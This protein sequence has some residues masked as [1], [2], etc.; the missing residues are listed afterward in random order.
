[1]NDIHNHLDHLS[2]DENTGP[3]FHGLTQAQLKP[4]IDDISR[5]LIDMERDA[6][7]RFNSSM[8]ALG[9]AASNPFASS[10]CEIPRIEAMAFRKARHAVNETFPCEPA[11]AP[12][13]D[14]AP[15]DRDSARPRK[16][17][18]HD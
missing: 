13:P 16:G 18:H 7:D 17:M 4:V 1:M 10:H 8:E 14:D 11:R 2:K 9:K 15:S 5:L 6:Y 3:V 12:D